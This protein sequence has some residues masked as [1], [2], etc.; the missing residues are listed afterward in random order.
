MKRYSDQILLQEDFFSN[1]FFA[2]FAQ[3]LRLLRPA[4]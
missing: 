4:V 3:L 1:F 2:F